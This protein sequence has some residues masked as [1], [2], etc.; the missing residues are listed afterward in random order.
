MSNARPPMPPTNGARP[1][2]PESYKATIRSAARDA[3]LVT[4]RLELARF[5]AES[6]AGSGTELHVLGHIVGPDRVV[7]ASPFGHGSDETVAVSTLL[8]IA[9]QLVSASADLFQDGRAYAA[10]ALLRQLVEVEYLAWA[11]EA[12]SG[13]GERWLR[14][15]KKEREA[16]FTPAKLRKAAGGKF[17]GQDYGYHCEFGGHPVPG[18][19]L[20]LQPSPETLQLLLSDVIGH[21]GRI[22]EHFAVWAGESQYGAPILSRTSQMR[23]RFAAWKSADPLV[24][25]PPPPA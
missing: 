11:M 2:D 1:P 18:A 24:G 23:E 12:R 9:S 22:W 6:L 15:D 7:G 3:S 5:V 13:E 8:R 4:L 10:A 19:S 25:L 21:A 17:R 20:L 16:F 14:S